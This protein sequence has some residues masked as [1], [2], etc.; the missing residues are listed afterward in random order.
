[1]GVPP[2]EHANGSYGTTRRTSVLDL[3]SNGEVVEGQILPADG[4]AIISDTE[5][6]FFR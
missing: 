2:E 4:K 5:T 3:S 6:I 1:M